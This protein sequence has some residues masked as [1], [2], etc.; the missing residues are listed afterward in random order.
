MQAVRLKLCIKLLHTDIE[1]LSQQARDFN[2]ELRLQ[3]E[4]LRAEINLTQ[5][6]TGG[7]QQQINELEVV[8]NTTCSESKFTMNMRTG[9]S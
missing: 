7:L 9:S 3:L 6:T 2:T 8:L 5:L 4:G 1:N